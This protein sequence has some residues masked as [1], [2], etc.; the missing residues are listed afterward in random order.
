MTA[1]YTLV[2]KFKEFMKQREADYEVR[3]K[4]SK[5]MLPMVRP[6]LSIKKGNGF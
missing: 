3:M 1:E 2:L 6:V 4:N 5:K